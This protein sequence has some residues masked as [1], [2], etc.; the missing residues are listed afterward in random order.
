MLPD[1]PELR[2]WRLAMYYP[3]ALQQPL[4]DYGTA[5]A[6]LHNGVISCGAAKSNLLIGPSVPR[7]GVFTR[8]ASSMP[9]TS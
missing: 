3:S 1:P 5:L 8:L 9:S 7:G 2:F 6:I 4:S